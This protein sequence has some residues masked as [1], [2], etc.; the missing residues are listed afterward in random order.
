MFLFRESYTNQRCYMIQCGSLLFCLV[1]SVIFSDIGV[2]S[3]EFVLFCCVCLLYIGWWYKGRVKILQNTF[4]AT[5]F[6][7]FSMLGACGLCKSC[8]YI[9][10]SLLICFEVQCGVNCPLTSSDFERKKN[11]KLERKIQNTTIAQW[12][13]A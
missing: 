11:Q 8:I 6:C 5:L 12:L 2:L 4:N 13:Y 10:I 3:I 1:S 7:A 9:S